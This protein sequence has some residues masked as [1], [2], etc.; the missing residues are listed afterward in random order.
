MGG[1]VNDAGA[2][3]DPWNTTLPGAYAAGTAGN[4]VGN[5]PTAEQIADAL[6]DMVDAIE[7]GLTPRQALRLMTSV[8][9]GEVSGAGTPTITFRNAIADDTVR[10]TADVDEAGNRTTITADLD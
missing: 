2:A 4:I 8:L 10:I 5:Q 9:G 6:L 3:G 1:L 7:A